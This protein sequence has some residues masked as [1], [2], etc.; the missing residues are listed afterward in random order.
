MG[1][2]QGKCVAEGREGGGGEGEMNTR[3]ECM[4]NKQSMFSNTL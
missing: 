1:G 2:N 3:Q 4:R